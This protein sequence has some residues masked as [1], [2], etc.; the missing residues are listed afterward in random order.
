VTAASAPVRVARCGLGAGVC[1]IWDWLDM[2][3]LLR[4]STAAILLFLKENGFSLLL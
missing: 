4:T 1:D 2:H 3:R